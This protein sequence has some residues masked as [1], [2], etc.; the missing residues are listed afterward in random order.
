MVTGF[1]EKA[2]LFGGAVRDPSVQRR[3]PC[4]TRSFC[5]FT[6][7]LKSS[8]KYSIATLR[9]GSSWQP[10]A[11]MVSAKNTLSTL[12]IGAPSLLPSPGRN[13]VWYQSSNL[14]ELDFQ[15]GLSEGGWLSAGDCVDQSSCCCGH[16]LPGAY[17]SIF[18]RPHC[19]PVVLLHVSKLSNEDCLPSNLPGYLMSPGPDSTCRASLRYLD[20]SFP[21]WVFTTHVSEPWSLFQGDC[22][23]PLLGELLGQNL[24][25]CSPHQVSFSIQALYS[26]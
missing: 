13:W 12:I 3:S 16:Q 17:G 20:G 2:G 11:F 6:S 15:S 21:K 14:G 7:P 10:R 5:L 25:L 18:H 4:V 26:N 22:L 1:C 8:Y 23:V 9:T 19:H 24:G